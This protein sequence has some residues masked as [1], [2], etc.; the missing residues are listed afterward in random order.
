[1]SGG[2]ARRVGSRVVVGVWAFAISFGTLVIAT[3]PLAGGTVPA[4]GWAYALLLLAVLVT[5]PVAAAWV[6]ARRA[7]PRRATV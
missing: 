1:M 6:G 2:P 4:V 5:A 3:V 7:I